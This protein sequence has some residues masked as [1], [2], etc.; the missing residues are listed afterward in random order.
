MIELMPERK[1][2]DGP[3]DDYYV[4]VRPRQHRDGRHRRHREEEVKGTEHTLTWGKTKPNGPG[5]EKSMAQRTEA[6]ALS[7]SEEDTGYKNSLSSG[8]RGHEGEGLSRGR[9]AGAP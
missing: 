8:C 2:E 9:C 4:Q 5:T 1:R 6:Y 7:F 3:T